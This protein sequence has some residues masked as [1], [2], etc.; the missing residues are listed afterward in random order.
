LGCQDASRKRRDSSQDPGAWAGCVLRTRGGVF[1][2]VSED[3]WAKMKRLLLELKGLLDSQPDELPRKRLEVIRGFLNY[4]T[5]TY[6]YMIPYLN[7]L[8]MTIDGWRSNRTPDGWKLPESKVRKRDEGRSQEERDQA[9]EEDADIPFLVKA[10]PRL[11]SDVEALWAL[12]EADAPPWRLA[13]PKHSAVVTY[14]FGDA[15]GSAYGGASQVA[16]SDEFHFQFGQWIARVTENESSNWREFTNL[17][18][19]L[20]ER[21][22]AGLLDDGEVF[23]FTDNSMAEGA[24]WKGTSQSPKLCALVLRLRKLEMRTGMILHIIHVSGK[25]MIAT[26]VDGLSRG[27]HSSGVMQGGVSDVLCAHP[28]V[29]LGEIAGPQALVGRHPGGTSG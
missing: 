25:R 18:E 29:R 3:K 11:F 27:D 21:G 6:R 1:A 7:G 16:G 28:P 15:S 10:K 19:Y 12:S 22:E 2:L 24:F 5:Q 4:V 8:H 13:R 26:G 17:V 14:G 9:R 23:M 20:E